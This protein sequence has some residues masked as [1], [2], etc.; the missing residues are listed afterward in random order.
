MKT[1]N[2]VAEA[3]RSAKKQQEFLQK[4][5]EYEKSH[6]RN[7]VRY[8]HG[9]FVWCNELRTFRVCF[10]LTQTQLANIVGVS[11]NTISLYEQS[12]QIPSLQIGL[13]IGQLFRVTPRFLFWEE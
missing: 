8:D 3:R 11:K 1:K 10:G 2:T 6:G 13:R 7:I 4:V 9:D 12:K 5:Y